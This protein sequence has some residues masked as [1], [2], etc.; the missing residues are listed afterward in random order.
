MSCVNVRYIYD[1]HRKIQIRCVLLQTSAA[2]SNLAGILALQADYGCNMVEIYG[3]T[4][5]KRVYY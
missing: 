4:I 2:T 3:Q 1:P 5:C